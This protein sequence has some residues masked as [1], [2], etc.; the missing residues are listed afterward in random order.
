MKRLIAAVVLLLLVLVGACLAQA[1]QQERY[2]YQ[3]VVQQG[4]VRYTET[5][6]TREQDLDDSTFHTTQRRVTFIDKP[7]KLAEL[8]ARKADLQAQ[9]SDLQSRIN[10]L[11]ALP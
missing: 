11:Q 9:A 10:A 8:T 6:E 1:V 5:Y 4:E 7:Q 3:R 2:T